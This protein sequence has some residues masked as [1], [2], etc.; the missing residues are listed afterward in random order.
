M[1]CNITV[2]YLHISKLFK[3]KCYVFQRMRVENVF[4]FLIPGSMLI[5]KGFLLPLRWI[6]IHMLIVTGSYNVFLI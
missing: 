1:Q 5:S 3:A 2:S 6:E 4:F